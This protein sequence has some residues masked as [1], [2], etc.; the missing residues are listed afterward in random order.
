MDK[1]LLQRLA[2]ATTATERETILLDMSLAALPP[3]M[4][5]AVT[6]AA[7]PHWVDGRFFDALF[8]EDATNL[9]INLALLSFVEQVPTQG[10]AIHERT[11]R[12]LLNRL[13]RQD[14]DQF[15]QLS[16][17][18]AAYCAERAA[19]TDDSDWQA[20]Q[21]YHRL[22]SDPD[23]GIADLRQLAT[24][25]ANYQY[26]TYDDIERTLQLADEQITAGRLTPEASNWVRLWQAKL[27]LIF[28]APE[29]AALSLGQIDRASSE[30]MRFAAELAELE[31]DLL[32]RIEAEP[33]KIKTAYQTAITHYQALPNSSG[34]LDAYLVQEKLR[35][36]NLLPPQPQAGES[37]P[38]EKPS[39]TDAQLIEN[40]HQVWIE[41]VLNNALD[42]QIDLRMARDGTHGGNLTYHRPSGVDMPLTGGDNRLSKLFAAAQQSLLILGSPGSGKTITLLQLLDELLQQAEK[43]TNQPIP[44]LFNPSSF[45]RFMVDEDKTFTDWLADEAYNQYRLNRSRFRQQLQAG[46]YTLLLDGLDEVTNENSERDQTVRVI[47]VFM[48]QSRCGLVVCSRIGDYQ[49]L[50]NELELTHVLV[51]QPLSNGQIKRYITQLETPHTPAML[52]QL[53]TDWQLHEALRSPLL[54]TLYMK[55]FSIEHKEQ[56]NTSIETVKVQ[57]QNIFSR[58]VAYVFDQPANRKQSLLIENSL[59][60]LS[61]LAKRL[62]KESNAIFY[63]E[64]MQPSWLAVNNSF[65]FERATI[66][67]LAAIASIFMLVQHSI[68]VRPINGFVNG[69]IAFFTVVSLLITIP[70]KR[71]W[72]KIISSNFL[73]WIAYSLSRGFLYTILGNSDGTQL[74]EF[75]AAFLIQ[76]L[77]SLI[78]GMVIG[79]GLLIPINLLLLSEKILTR[80]QIKIIKPSNK[81]AFRLLSI[82][83]LWGLLVGIFVSV[84][85]SLVFTF[86]D[87]GASNLLELFIVVG[88]VFGL[89]GALIS[90]FMAI[91]DTPAV[92]KRLVPGKG[93]TTSFINGLF[94]TLTVA[95]F[96]LTLG[97]SIEFQLTRELVVTEASLFI[98]LF[99]TFVWYG[100]LAWC[101]HWALRWVLARNGDLPL[102]LVPW[103][104]EMVARGLMRRVGGGYIFIHRSLLE[105]FASLE[106]EDPTGFP[107]V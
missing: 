83:L 39:K 99:P 88:G 85:S 81:K 94:A 8:G 34:Q 18:A 72:F 28:N 86:L 4:Q 100:G 67:V 13:W 36:R 20:E 19:E 55:A 31:G 76:V 38:K 106:E 41:G 46:R 97:V 104:D 5:E 52:T 82:G 24:A 44:L 80:E 21:V 26:H 78:L 10:Y 96:S 71:K 29:R 98:I 66:L 103:L 35:Q 73:A 22:V 12:Q 101:K 27:A 32:V 3:E 107:S 91:L 14:P 92:A 84:V 69:L 16:S 95:L 43:D 1:T 57:R 9:Y 51:L 15:R 40:V 62:Q 102:R 53:E 47:N 56:L 77:V 17:R 25:W 7:V 87:T 70:M 58:Y 105:Y 65:A 60:W 6:V 59:H 64:E 75:L 68:I 61:T 48:Q 93:I 90:I 45:A 11:R 30:D 89:M 54:L 33:E 37:I 42:Q 50:E 79:L 2:T 74:F 23:Q 49:L 63:I